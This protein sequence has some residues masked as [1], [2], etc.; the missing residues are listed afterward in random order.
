MK[1]S[2][3]VPDHHLAFT[4]AQRYKDSGDDAGHL[5][6]YVLRESASALQADARDALLAVRPFFADRLADGIES[7]GD[8]QSYEAMLG[9]IDAA[10]NAREPK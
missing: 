7:R 5:A 9:I 4:L 8:R 6:R 3:G 1:R 10:L 2:F